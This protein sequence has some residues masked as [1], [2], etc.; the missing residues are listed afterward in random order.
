MF[1]FPSTFIFKPRW[2]GQ[3]HVQFFSDETSQSNQPP[4]EAA[5]RRSWFLPCL[6]LQVSGQRHGGTTFSGEKWGVR[7]PQWLVGPGVCVEKGIRVGEAGSPRPLLPHH[8]QATSIS[9]PGLT[10]SPSSLPA[11]PAEAQGTEVQGWSLRGWTWPPWT[12]AH[13]SSRSGVSQANQ[14]LNKIINM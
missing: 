6:H 1:L 10:A 2:P 11:T 5:S 13:R 9:C 8:L 14:L 12:Q 3:R 4:G 7:A